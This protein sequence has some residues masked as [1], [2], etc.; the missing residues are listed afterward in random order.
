MLALVLKV[1]DVVAELM[2]RDFEGV[3]GQSSAVVIF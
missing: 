3:D 2:L 1:E